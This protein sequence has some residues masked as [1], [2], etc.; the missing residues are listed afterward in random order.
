MKATSSEVLGH[1]SLGSTGAARLEV[2]GSSVTPV[3]IA[4]GIMAED[5]VA[6]ARAFTRA[7]TDG[8][9]AGDRDSQTDTAS[10]PS[11]AQR[12]IAAI[13]IA[14]I[15][16]ARSWVPGVTASAV[17]FAAYLGGSVPLS[18]DRLEPTSIAEAYLVYAC[19]RDDAASIEWFFAEFGPDIE[20][21][22][23]RFGAVDEAAWDLKQAILLKLVTATPG[24]SAKLASY[25]GQ[26]PL[27]AFVRVAASRMVIDHFRRRVMQ[28][29]T[30]P[31]DVDEQNLTDEAA[32]GE[33][34]M[35]RHWYRGDIRRAFEEAF[36]ELEPRD[37]RL[38]RNLILHRMPFEDI[39]VLFGV[40]RTT[41][42][43]W[44]ERARRRLLDTAKRRLRE[45]LGM[46]AATVDSLVAMG[47]ADLELSVHRL[48]ASSTGDSEP[49]TEL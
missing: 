38:L 43:R 14:G 6:M 13:L 26:G 16:Q 49:S 4:S 18:L 11:G 44:C 46:G 9:L 33:D 37:R 45:S 42:A 32:D 10:S 15:E 35:L 20:R 31:L 28:P 5:A 47:R 12:V 39:G 27:R 22:V 40:H 21:M 41:A 24:S 34:A 2:A 3:M 19:G 25:R 23:A 29:E 17:D 48:L 30:T 1:A 7:S 8:A 36:A